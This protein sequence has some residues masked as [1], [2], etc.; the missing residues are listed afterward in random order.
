MTEH[1]RLSHVQNAAWLRLTVSRLWDD[2]ALAEDAL[3]LGDVER[4]KTLLQ[5][6]HHW[7]TTLDDNRVLFVDGWVDD[8]LFPL[9]PFRVDFDF[10]ETRGGAGVNWQRVYLNRWFLPFG[11]HRYRWTPLVKKVL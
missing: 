11:K 1:I 8:W 6:R 9:R 2:I 5:R 10:W 3:K 7:A 4:A